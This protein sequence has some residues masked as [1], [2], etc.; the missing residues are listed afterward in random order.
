ML[1]PVPPLHVGLVGQ[2]PRAP[3]LLLQVLPEI[4]EQADLLA[5]L[6]A[7]ILHRHQPNMVLPQLP[8]ALNV[9][10]RLGVIRDHLG[11]VVEVDPQMPVGQQVA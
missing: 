8:V 11:A 9:V 5:Q 2:L 7:C 1:G 4:V 6:R 3:A 10:E